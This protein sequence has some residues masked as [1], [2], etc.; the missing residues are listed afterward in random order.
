M[1][2]Y[3]DYKV[4]CELDAAKF[5]IQVGNLVKDGWQLIGGVSATFGSWVQPNKPGTQHGVYLAQALAKP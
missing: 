1:N 5:N 3:K 4:I 2:Q